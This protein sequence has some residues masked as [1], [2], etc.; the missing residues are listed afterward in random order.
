MITPKLE[1]LILC[2]KAFFKTAVIGGSKTT[3]NIDIDRFIIITDIT[4]LPYYDTANYSQE[5]VDI[6]MQLSIYGERG[7]NH[8]VFCNYRPTTVPVYTADPTLPFYGVEDQV[9]KTAI[10]AQKIDCYILHTTAVGFSFIL[11][12][13]FPTAT[14]GVAAFNNPAFEPP[15]DYGKDG[16]AGALNVATEIA[17]SLGFNNQVVNRATGLGVGSAITQQ[18]QFPA[19]VG[20]TPNV[21]N[22][23]A[24]PIANINYVEILGQPN[25]IGI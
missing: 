9:G 12:T 16:M 13:P 20:T 5:L 4:Y 19:T 1:E 18:I 14:I 8:Y 23:P 21:N 11:G 10:N 24:M 2:G 3:I 6:N 7:F 22:N 15:L 17:P 25:N